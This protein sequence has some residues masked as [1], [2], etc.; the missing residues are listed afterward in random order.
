MAK[1]YSAT[2]Q[3]KDANMV[4]TLKKASQA[5]KDLQKSLT[6]ISKTPVK[7][8]AKLGS[9]FKNVENNISKITPKTKTIRIE[10]TETVTK[11]M[12]NVQRNM[13]EMSNKINSSLTSSMK[14][15]NASI[16]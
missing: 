4:S 16:S 5:A 8:E 2:L 9:S 11:T 6:Q 7:I 1:S 3:L 15:F 13:F 14:G 12:N 10:A